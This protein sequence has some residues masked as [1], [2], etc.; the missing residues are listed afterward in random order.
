MLNAGLAY[1]FSVY[2]D[3]VKERFGL[4]Q[5]EVAGVGTAVNL[6]GYLAIFPGAFYDTLRRYNRKGPLL[7]MLGGVVIHC[8]GYFALHAALVGRL[9]PPYWAV[10]GIALVAGNGVTWFETAAL[11]T[12]VRNFETERGTVI[13]ILKAF[14]GLSASAYVTLY[15][16]FLD[17]NAI[18][19]VLMLAILPALLCLLC[20]PF[21]N[22]V[23][24][25]QV[26]PHTKSHAFHLALTAVV[27][28][29][30]YQ[31]V[32]AIA[33]REESLDFWAGVLTSSA[34]GILLL[35]V[36]AIPLIFGGLRS[37][38][39]R[40]LNPTPEPAEPAARADSFPPELAAFL[41][42]G[43][44]GGS[45]GGS[46]AAAANVY[47]NRPPARCLRSVSFWMLLFVNG[48]CSGAGLTLLNN[49]AQLVIALG[50]QEGA[51]SVFI[52]VYSIANCLGRLTSGFLPDRLLRLH[53]VPRTVSLVALAA[54]A[55]GA[56][57]LN[58]FATLPL[59]GLA[60][61][62][63]GFTFGG[64][65]GVVPAV[66]SELFGL[67]HFATNYALTQLGPAAGSS[68]LATWLAGELYA[69]ALARHGGGTACRGPDCFRTTFL[70][71]AG[72]AAAALGVAV[73]LWHRT[74]PLY[75]KVIAW[76]KTERSKRG[77]KSE[78]E[79]GQ[80]LMRRVA[81]ENRHLHAIVR[82]GRAAVGQLEAALPSAPP[83]AAVAAAANA[84]SALVQEA[85]GMLAEQQRVY[86]DSDALPSMQAL[87]G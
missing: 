35:P 16:S 17:P 87:T 57:L 6:G 48:A 19:F 41:L 40:D 85:D 70:I 26:E 3:A 84:L 37:R 74:R 34:A 78:L 28:L 52:S 43:G 55:V 65:Q 10:L 24:Y 14:L 72:L 4:S 42:P 1:A 50:G 79:E 60:A 12:C 21:I 30:S 27:G 64:F 83:S 33:R 20:S 63:S 51:Q 23:P 82:R 31:A 44:P 58:A 53:N 38:R 11:V 67:Q 29:A 75:V 8:A 39:L 13:G 25:I 2:S 80:R 59:L 56:A 9:Q 71:L 32:V 7:T 54:L 86:R 46:A 69:R 73:V 66:T 47:R 81:S 5:T 45:G 49:M 77:L 15:V 61:F 76:T 62:L 18:A 68:L 22:Y 36:L